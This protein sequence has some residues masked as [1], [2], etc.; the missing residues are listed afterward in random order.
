MIMSDG[1]RGNKDGIGH[2]NYQYHALVHE[3]TV[4][5]QK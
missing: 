3:M 2:G 1:E 5:L 4:Y